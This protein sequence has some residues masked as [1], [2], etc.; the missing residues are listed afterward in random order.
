[1]DKNGFKKR[2]VQGSDMDLT[3]EGSYLHRQL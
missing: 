2:A 1:M 3:L